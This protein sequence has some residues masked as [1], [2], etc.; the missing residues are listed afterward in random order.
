MTTAVELSR[1]AA[2]S[3]KDLRKGDRKLFDRVAR[4]LN[5]L[6]SEPQLGKALHG[7]LRG[8]RSLRVGPLRI[9]YTY[10]SGRLIVF[11]LDIG[12][13]GQIYR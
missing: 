4:A 10:D 9:I 3:L 5:R 2:S 11:V 13:R 6:A 8:R 12:E 7:Q 1:G